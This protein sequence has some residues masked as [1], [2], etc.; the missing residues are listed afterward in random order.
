[1]VNRKKTLIAFG[2]IPKDGGTFT[3]YRNLRGPLLDHG[4]DLRCVSVGEREARL[5]E[6][7]FADDGCV[8]LAKNESSIKKQ[9][10]EFCQWCEQHSVDIVM[11]VNSIAILSALPHLR[12]NIRIMSR[13]ANAFDHGYRITM[14]C[15]ERLSRIV[16]LAP[17]QVED[18]VSTYGADRS[19]VTLIPNGTSAERFSDAALKER[20]GEGPLRLGFLGRL[21]HKQKGVFFLPEILSKLH[22]RGLDFSLTIAG[23]GVHEIML[24]RELDSFIQAGKVKFVGALGRDDIPDYLSNID[25]YLFPSQFE[26]SPNALLEA[27]MA[28]CVPAAWL[29]KGITDFIIDD[30][31][32]GVLAEIGDC[33]ALADSISHLAMENGNFVQIYILGIARSVSRNSY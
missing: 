26:G 21:E 29:L 25:V 12:E 5:W 2:T 16:A 19:R 32:T 10:Y 17:R 13:C 1:L 3:F 7:S 9:A 14:A 20:G 22:S 18:L 11:G 15:Q 33:D 8:L 28:G 23:K 6:E 31:S 30:G 4:I 24:R 27:M